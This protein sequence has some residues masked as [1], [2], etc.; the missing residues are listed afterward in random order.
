VVVHHYLI[1]FSIAVTSWLSASAYYC[2][3][4][5]DVC[6]PLSYGSAVTFF[7][8]ETSPNIFWSKMSTLQFV[9]K[10]SL[11]VELCGLNCSFGFDSTLLKSIII[12]HP[13][14]VVFWLCQGSHIY[15]LIQEKKL[16]K[17]VYTMFVRSNQ[18]A[19]VLAEGLGLSLS[20]PSLGHTICML[21]LEGECWNNY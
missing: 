11:P 15:C 8:I 13:I 17:E 4:N 21:Q 2:Q 1:L 12:S 20:I 7:V 10:S 9:F 3:P 5:I 14:P 19:N 18:L 6:W 16:S